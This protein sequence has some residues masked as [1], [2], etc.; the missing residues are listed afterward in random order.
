M[1]VFQEASTF[2]AEAALGRASEAT[3][4]LDACLAQKS[5]YRSS[6]PSEKCKHRFA[7]LLTQTELNDKEELYFIQ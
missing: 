5:R 4:A 6:F 7:S 1:E 2:T 3:E